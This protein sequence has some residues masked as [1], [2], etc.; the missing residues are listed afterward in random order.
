M[1]YENI[2]LST[3]F[4]EYNFY[5]AKILGIVEKT[6]KI[7]R[8][9]T[10][11]LENYDIRNNFYLLDCHK[12][13]YCMREDI[14]TQEIVTFGGCTN[15]IKVNIECMEMN[16]DLIDEIFM[17]PSE[18]KSNSFYF[19]PEEDITIEYKETKTYPDCKEIDLDNIKIYTNLN[20]ILVFHRCIRTP[21][22]AV[23]VEKKEIEK[24]INDYNVEHIKEINLDER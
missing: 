2:D 1:Y 10:K 21:F 24:I 17:I 9:N 16:K 19:V 20:N 11:K 22:T 5:K 18:G 3:L 15:D 4:N 23:S 8:D 14:V 13:L 7:W 6:N 12:K